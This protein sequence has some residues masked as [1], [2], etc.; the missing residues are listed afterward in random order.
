MLVPWKKSYDKPRQHIKKQRH[1]FVDKGPYSQSYGF[2]SSHVW[3]WEL[4]HKEGCCPFLPLCNPMDCSL[5][6]SSVH[7][8]L[9]ARIL[10]WVTMSFS[11][12]SSWPR[13]WTQVT[14]IAGRLF[15][16]WATWEAHILHI[17]IYITYRVFILFQRI[18]KCI[19]TYA[20][21]WNNPTK[22]ITI[23]QQG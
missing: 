22:Q 2:L 11:R 17:M 4:G 1:Y 5:P 12:G 8:V 3:M 21:I 23:Y 9:Q 10:E 20:Y 13:D 16:V 6:G 15:T 18:T 19:I 14:R 7:G